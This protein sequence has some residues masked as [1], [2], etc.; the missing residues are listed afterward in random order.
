[1]RATFSRRPGQIGIV[2]GYSETCD[3]DETK[4]L[5]LEE[6][7]DDL[8]VFPV[9]RATPPAFFGHVQPIHRTSPFTASIS[10]TLPPALLP[11]NSTSAFAS[12]RS[13]V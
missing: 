8:P 12:F 6:S 10:A 11:P 7:L 9:D 13:A 1:M 4:V 3:F 2:L 5:P